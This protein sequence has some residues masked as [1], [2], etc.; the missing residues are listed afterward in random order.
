M[1]CARLLARQWANPYNH[2]VKRVIYFTKI[3]L[4]GI[5]IKNKYKMN[6]TTV[7]ALGIL[8]TAAAA[9]FAEKTGA[10]KPKAKK[11]EEYSG[12]KNSDLFC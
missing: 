4:C 12:E 8:F 11:E 9:I 6:K 1:L 5:L 7:L 2:P 3:K 10:K